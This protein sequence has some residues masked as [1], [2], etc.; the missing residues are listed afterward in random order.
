MTWAHVWFLVAL[1]GAV[2]AGW[3]AV[4]HRLLLAALV[5]VAAFVAGTWALNLWPYRK[6]GSWTR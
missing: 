3:L 6:G 1:V 4:D 5:L 2:L